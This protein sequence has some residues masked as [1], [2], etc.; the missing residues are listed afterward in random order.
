MLVF[1]FLGILLTFLLFDGLLTRQSEDERVD[2]GVLDD[3]ILAYHLDWNAIREQKLLRYLYIKKVNAVVRYQN[4]AGVD[5]KQAC[6]AVEH[7]LAHP[8]LLPEIPQKRRPAMPETQDKQL[9]SLIAN[10]KLSEAATL[11]A[12]LLEVDQFT[13]QQVIER[14]EREQY[15]ESIAD[16][17]V[18]RLLSGDDETHA[19]EI[20][21]KR[22]GL[23]QSEAIHAID[24]MLEQMIV[25]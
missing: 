9:R 17:D 2:N 24:A 25:D 12:D 3:S 23:T 15:V 6:D 18:T 4:L 11:Y 5:Y 10:G 1:G 19:V 8:E 7:L 14:M 22:Y 16:E 13:A 21:R 20:L